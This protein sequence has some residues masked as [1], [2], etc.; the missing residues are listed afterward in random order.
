MIPRAAVQG[1]L[2]EAGLDGWLFYYFQRNDPIAERLLALPARELFT[3]RWF[4]YIPARGAPSKILHAIEPKALAH[5]P[6]RP[7]FY[8]SWRTLEERLARLLRGR[9]AAMQYSPKN[10]VP[11]V[12]RVDAGTVELVRAAGAR[13]ASSQDLVQM[14]EAPLSAAQWTSHQS[15]ARH[16]HDIVE[17]AFLWIAKKTR[18][19]GGVAEGEAQ[20]WIL[21]QYGRRRLISNA[22]P[23][24]A[25]GSH[26]GL[27]HYMPPREGRIIRRGEWVLLDIWAKGRGPS[28]A[29]A[30]ITWCGYVGENVP[31]RHENIFQI[32]RQARDKALALVRE[33]WSADKPLRGWQV[34]RA[35]RSHIARRGY[36]SFFTHRTGH[37]MGAE[38]HANGA[39]MDGHE[40]WETR[41]LLRRTLFSIEPGIYLK[42]FGARSEINVYLAPGR[43]LVSGPLQARV[44][45]LLNLKRLADVAVSPG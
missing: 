42:D 41:R 17:G 38:D 25:A 24:V 44:A 14:F 27:P 36:G 9:S 22:P 45:P 30:D 18:R 8:S 3:R 5:L 1:A 10:A 39:N 33:S 20:R 34:D 37:S 19:G 15:A 23:I 16:L 28:A 32:V 7:L 35:A 12:S 6:G 2:R 26:S 4:Y 13:V 43:A 11:Y 29:Y 21:S 31:S 40:T